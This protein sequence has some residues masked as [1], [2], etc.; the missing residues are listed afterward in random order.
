MPALKSLAPS[1][2]DS[3]IPQLKRLMRAAWLAVLFAPVLALGGCGTSIRNAPINAAIAQ[4]A[5]PRHRRRPPRQTSPRPMRI[6]TI[7]WSA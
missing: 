5:D 1:S 3:T 7:R 4:P 6:S 2:G